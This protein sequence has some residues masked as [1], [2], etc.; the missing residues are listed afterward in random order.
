MKD[1][2]KQLI[3][4]SVKPLLLFVSYFIK[5]RPNRV[6][7]SAYNGR[8]ACNPKYIYDELKKYDELDIIWVY[9]NDGADAFPSGA[10]LVKRRTLKHILTYYSSRVV[11]E[12][13]SFP[14]FLPRKKGQLYLNT[15]HGGGAIK[16]VGFACDSIGDVAAEILNDVAAKT[17]VYLS[18]SKLKSDTDLRVDHNYNG[19]IFKT[20]MPRNDVFFIDGDEIKAKVRAYYNIDDAKKI[21]LYA[22]T[23]RP[24]IDGK[25]SLESRMDINRGEVLSALK[26]RFGGDWVLMERAHHN[27]H[28]M[29]NADGVI[30]ATDY[31]D[32][33]ELLVTADVLITDYSSS[34][35]DFGLTGKP[36]FSVA[37]DYEEFKNGRGF[38]LEGEEWCCVFTRSNEELCKAII[39]F[40]EEKYAKKLEKYYADSVC[41]DN[42]TAS[43]TVAKY[44]NMLC[45][46]KIDEEFIKSITE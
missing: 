7:L 40:D 30:N 44:I 24:M 29:E 4:K 42:G 12:N 5:I 34:T 1:K 14:I 33:Q 22:P 28:N 27:T 3:K 46:G 39:G 10:K 16:K 15:G 23:F 31:P 32:M 8:Y 19:T 17:D 36:A 41:Y 45:K 21:V 25:R 6:I 9:G 11:V 43:K 20:G 18:S 2:Q 26:E 38:F 37:V 35:W 13:D